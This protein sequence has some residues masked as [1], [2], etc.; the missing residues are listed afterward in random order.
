VS[1]S[2]ALALSNGS[3]AESG[4]AAARAAAWRWRSAGSGGVER[5]QG[6]SASSQV[7]AA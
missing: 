2:S 5:S 7:V 3:N 1:L 4:I 6:S